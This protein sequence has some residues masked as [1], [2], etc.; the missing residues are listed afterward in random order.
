MIRLL[1]PAL[2]LVAGASVQE[3]EDRRLLE[4]IRTL[5]IDVDFRDTP[6][7]GVADFIADVADINVFVHREVR[8]SSDTVTL[9]VKDVSIRSI[10]NLAL[11]SKKFGFRVRDGVLHIAPREEFDK[12]VKL[13]LIDVRDLLYPIRDFP[14]VEMTLT[15]AGA[16]LTALSEA[17][18]P[19]EF[20]LV[21]LI[22]AH[23]GGR[24]WQE[25]P[26]TSIRLSN[27]ILVV[28]QTPE[29][30]AQIRRVVDYLR[31]NK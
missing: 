3:G 6:V 29:V 17:V 25:N 4:K 18:E 30:I 7:A 1:L 15:D 8:E 2:A 11:A 5:K 31:R 12:D 21:D 19:A 13:E 14:G 24:S 22:Q 10:L 27:G 26:R 9:R 20:P 16:G 23:V 28:R